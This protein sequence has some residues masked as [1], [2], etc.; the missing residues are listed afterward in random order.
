MTVGG[1]GTLNV[2]DDQI[3][4]QGNATLNAGGLDVVIGG[5]EV[6]EI[7]LDDGEAH[8]KSL[9]VKAGSDVRLRVPG[10]NLVVDDYVKNIGVIEVTGSTLK[11]KNLTIGDAVAAVTIAETGPTPDRADCPINN[12]YVSVGKTFTINNATPL[13]L[14]ILSGPRSKLG[15]TTAKFPISFASI[16]GVCLPATATF[17]P[18]QLLPTAQSKP[19]TALWVS[20][21]WQTTAPLPDRAR[22]SWAIPQR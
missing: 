10:G 7:L 4:V 16:A 18:R 15:V 3:D 6:G 17:L 5:S 19:R 21:S 1:A 2:S 8:F 20:T 22:S 13:T 9:N 12:A 14:N 11:A